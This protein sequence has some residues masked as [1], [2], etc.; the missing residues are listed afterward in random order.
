MINKLV[1]S[2]YFQKPVSIRSA[3]SAACGYDDTG[4]NDLLHEAGKHIS[5]L[6]CLAEMLLD[7]VRN[8]EM[9]EPEI[10][11]VLDNFIQK[12]TAFHD[13]T[14]LEAESLLWEEMA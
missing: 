5:T 3:I 12:N 14:V 7:I 13:Q 11:D 8:S 4:D 9:Q 10:A 1:R 2:I 6:E